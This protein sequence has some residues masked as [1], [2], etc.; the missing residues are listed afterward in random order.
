LGQTLS[1][2]QDIAG[3]DPGR[4]ASGIREN[5]AKTRQSTRNRSAVV[6]CV[7]LTGCHGDDFGGISGNSDEYGGMK[8]GAHGFRKR[9]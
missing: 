7:R 9:E 1:G 3:T 8:I 4:G 2:K 6:I 5:E